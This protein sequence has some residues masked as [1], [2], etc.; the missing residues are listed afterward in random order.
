MVKSTLETEALTAAALQGLYEALYAYHA[1]RG[2]KDTAR[3][4]SVFTEVIEGLDEHPKGS[5]ELNAIDHCLSGLVK[6][7][8]YRK[9]KM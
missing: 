4:L 5:F 2:A 1:R 3:L 7:V 6:Q 8:I 9:T